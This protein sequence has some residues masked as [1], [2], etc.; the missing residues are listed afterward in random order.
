VAAVQQL[1]AVHRHAH[2]AALASLTQ[3]VARAADIVQTV[4]VAHHVQARRNVQ[5]IVRVEI[6]PKGSLIE[7]LQTYQQAWRLATVSEP[8]GADLVKH[9]R[10]A[11]QVLGVR[12]LQYGTETSLCVAPGSAHQS[13]L[14]R[15]K[16]VHSQWILGGQ[17]IRHQVVAVRQ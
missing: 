3:Q 14:V 4:A 16:I 13:S 9:V 11:V 8:M 2:T 7:A 5:R 17:T 12:D 15:G 6:T 1:G 10:R